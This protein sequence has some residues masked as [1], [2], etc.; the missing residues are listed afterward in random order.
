MRRVSKHLLLGC[1]E[2]G[3]GGQGGKLGAGVAAGPAGGMHRA[4]PM[5]TH[6]TASSWQDSKYVAGVAP[7]L[8][9]LPVQSTQA[10]V[11]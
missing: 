6:S 9:S 3:A 7:H 2:V 10:G 8:Q 1:S 11:G 4:A 5:R